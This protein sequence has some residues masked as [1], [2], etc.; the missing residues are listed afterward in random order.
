[1]TP[2]FLGLLTLSATY[3]IH[4]PSLQN[5]GDEFTRAG[6][7]IG[8]G[9]YVLKEFVPQSHLK[10]Q[11][12]AHYWGAGDVAIDTVFFHNTENLSSE[13]N[14]Y[15]AGELDFTFNLPPGQFGWVKDNLAEELYVTPY[16]SMYY[17]LL[18]LSDPMFGNSTELRQALSMAIDREVLVEEVTKAGQVPAYGLVPPGVNNH[19][20]HEYEWKGQSREEQLK[21]AKAL[22]AKAGYSEDNPARFR[23]LYNTGEDHRNIA[24]AV[25]AMWK[26]NLGVEATLENQEFKVLLKTRLNQELWDVLRF[27][28]VGDYNDANTFLEI[29]ASDHGQNI[30][31]YNNPQ[32]D[33]LLRQAAAE[34]DLG[35]RSEL[36]QQA[37]DL[38]MS[39]YGILPL[40]YYVSKHLVKPRVKG[41]EPNIMKR[42]Q[43]KYLSLAP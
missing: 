8:N 5:H 18:D 32:F 25:A 33:E 22:Y 35:Q 34:T 11:R 13:L 43:T 14:R 19:Q 7:L 40:Y 1:P 37:E 36:L 15:R 3:P 41:F 30:N 27:A 23:L 16:L 29:F 4:T 9:P 10:L 17:Y 12:N 20:G 2:Y 42:T 28:W 39:D 21:Q 31:G 6:N 24:V 26:Q 38:F